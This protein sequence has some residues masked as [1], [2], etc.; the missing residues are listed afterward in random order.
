MENL[1]RPKT[2]K[3]IILILK[4]SIKKILRSDAFTGELYQKLFKELMPIFHKPF[5]P[6][7]EEERTHFY[8]FCEGSIMIILKPNKI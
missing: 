4:S 3:E 6:K 1:N 8:S 7:I 5:P 2:S